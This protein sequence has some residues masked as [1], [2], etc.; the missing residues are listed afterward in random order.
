MSR[1]QSSRRISLSG[2]DRGLIAT[3][4]L[5]AAVA[6]VFEPLY[7]FGCNWT[8]INDSCDK[9]RYVT[10]RAAAQIWRIYSKNWDPMFVDIPMW[11]RI[12]CS[13]EV[14]LFGPLYAITA[15]LLQQRSPWLP[16]VGYSFSGAL[17]YSTVVYF[18]ME[19]IEMLPGTNLFMVFAINIPWSILPV[20]LMYRVAHIY[21]ITY[22]YKMC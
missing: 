2:I 12:M 6:L 15:I 3:L 17:F 11:L 20:V 10:V 7:Y 9:S 5:F 19:C 22:S 16:V 8:D 21:P 14:F 18:A 13:V 4:W 1:I